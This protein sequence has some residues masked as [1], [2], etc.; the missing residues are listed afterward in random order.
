MKRPAWMS[1]ASE[2]RDG[3]RDAVDP[4]RHDVR[5]LEGPDEPGRRDEHAD[6]LEDE[7]EER[8][9]RRQVEAD[10]A[11]HQRVRQ[12][13]PAPDQQ[14]EEDDPG[15]RPP[16]AQNGEPLAETLEQAARRGRAADGAAPPGARERKPASASRWWLS[17]ISVVRIATI[18]HGQQQRAQ[19][20]RARSTGSP[21]PRRNGAGARKQMTARPS[22]SRSTTTV[23]NTALVLTCSRRPS[24]QART[25]SPAR[26]G[27]EEVDHE[28]DRERRQQ[29]ARRH[30]G[31]RPHEHPPAQ[32]AQPEAAQV[33]QAEEPEDRQA[34]PAQGRPPSR[35]NA[36]CAGRA[37]GRRRRGRRRPRSA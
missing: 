5:V 14:R 20:I 7:Q 36:R 12:P 27:E 9:V 6:R 22:K 32:R 4:E 26:A 3:L 37:R 30:V 23:A 31:E 24:S 29:T 25:I 15:D 18:G 16:G 1:S 35:R 11:H 8:R 13:A 34:H 21:A 33:H 28:A 2:M 19:R 17:R 10:L